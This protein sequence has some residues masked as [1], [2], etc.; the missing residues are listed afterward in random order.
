LPDR[1]TLR[2]FRRADLPAVMR[3]E[4]A[5]FGADAWPARD[6]LDFAR[7]KEGIFIVAMQGRRLIGYVLGGIM[8]VQGYIGS[9]AVHADYR[10]AGLGRLLLQRMIDRLAQRGAHEY[11]L[12]VNTNN[13]AAIGLYESLGFAVTATI[14]SYYLNGDPAHSMIRPGPEVLN[15]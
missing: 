1:L 14:D 13:I 10:R 7:D 2:R 6:F 5:S 15:C 4:R 8:G 9:I 11:G 12:H 3:I